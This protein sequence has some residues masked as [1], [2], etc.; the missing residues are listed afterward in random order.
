VRKMKTTDSVLGIEQL[1]EK[2]EGNLSFVDK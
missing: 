1:L 2:E